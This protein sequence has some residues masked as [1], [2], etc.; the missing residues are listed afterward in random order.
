MLGST[1]RRLS[2]KGSHVIVVFT[3]EHSL[4]RAREPEGVLPYLTERLRHESGLHNLTILD[5]RDAVPDAGFVDLVHLNSA[6]SR[7]FTPKLIDAIDGETIH[8]P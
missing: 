8:R 2:A 4:L 5:F 1:L 7:L 3:P 6:G